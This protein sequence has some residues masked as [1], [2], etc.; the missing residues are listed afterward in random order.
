[1]QSC[2]DAVQVHGGYGYT[3]EYGVE[4]QLR[5]A[6]GSRIYSGERAAEAPD[7]VVGYDK[8]Y[9]CS[10]ESTLGEVKEAVI[11][12]NLSRWS[13]NHLMD[14]EVVPGIL[15]SSQKLPGSGYALPDVTATL[16]AHYDVP[17]PAGMEGKD[18]FAH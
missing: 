15:V 5:D 13:G 17:F 18:I 16:L 4:R 12:D 7:I 3:T 9:G 8:G 1:V 2:L 6:V 11:E 14:P 10:D